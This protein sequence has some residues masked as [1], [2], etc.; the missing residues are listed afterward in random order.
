MGKV[1]ATKSRNLKA[2]TG[3][4]VYVLAEAARVSSIR[5]SGETAARRGKQSGRSL[6]SLRSWGLLGILGSGVPDN[7]TG[8]L[9]ILPCLAP[10]LRNGV[11]K[12]DLDIILRMHD[13]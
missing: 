4:K 7:A 9:S 6:F 10:S 2:L 1:A 3:W 8:E 11:Q 12:I 13:E 5:L